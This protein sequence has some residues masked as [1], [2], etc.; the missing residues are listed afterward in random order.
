MEHSSEV[1]PQGR[2]GPERCVAWFAAGGASGDTWLMSTPEHSLSPDRPS[3]DPAH[4]LF[5]HA[6]FARTLAKAIAGYK[7]PDGIVLA[8]YGP[9]GSGKSTVLAFVEYELG[10]FDEQVR[11]VVVT[12]NP[13][14]FS[15]QEHLA[16]AFLGQL[17]AVLPAKHAGFKELGKRLAQFSGAIGGAVDVAGAYF[18]VPLGGKVVEAGAKLL[19]SKPKDVPA[20]KGAISELLN[21]EKKRVLV[22]VDDIDRLAP[23]EVRQ[24]FTVI[25]ALAD[26]PY[27]T[28]LLAFDR[29]VA[30]TAISQQT[31]LPGDRYLEKI[32]Q[33]PFEL[34]RADRVTLRQALFSK[35]DQVIAGTPEG[36]F[37]SGYWQNVFA[38]LDPLFT[39]PRDVVRLTNALSVTYPAVMGEV[40]PVD[41]IALECIRVF[42]PQ[43]Y[44]AIRTSP[45]KFAGYSAPEHHEKQAEQAFH[46][47]WLTKV[48]EALR[49]STKELLERLF[50]RLES[51]WSN[52]H[53]GGDSLLSW[54][55]DLRVCAGEDIF[56]AYFRL[57]L[58][59]G[60]VSRA[61]IDALLAA[62]P[63]PK[64]FADILRA[65]KDQ[66]VPNG[67]SKARALLERLMDFVPEEMQAEH[68]QPVINA[69]FQVGD[70]LLLASDEGGGF[71]GS[72]NEVRVARI[73]FHLLKK[74]EGPQRFSLLKS[75]F[76]DAAALRCSQR[77][78]RWLAEAAEKGE[79]DALLT[80]ESTDALMPVWVERVE[81][82][83]ASP[84]FINRP[85]LGSLLSG[86]RHWGDESKVKAW[87]QQAAATGDGLLKLIDA[88]SYEVRT[89][90]FGDHAVHTYRRVKPKTVE[91]YLAPEAAAERV[92][93]M[94]AA[95]AVPEKHLEVAKE[96]VRAW[97]AFKAGVVDED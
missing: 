54:R 23:E 10:R 91:S 1:R 58:P 13:W 77:L 5:G 94:L 74:V 69:L 22:I 3:T 59:P 45:E 89:Q 90:G 87:T 6:P 24:L 44:D 60:A 9:W 20:L 56:Q 16:R 57:S 4:D 81:L 46:Q 8:L 55:R 18:G 38:G 71:F 64:A 19:A 53:Y 33:V 39:V 41:F 76:A 61:D 86:W 27:V 49:P 47:Q 93:A 51:V 96:Y 21:K 43:V 32:I 70:E 67:L 26:F 66:K 36:L 72:G 88:L 35:L 80:K 73:A 42:L 25:K 29:E 37:N 31:G 68:A 48:P 63:E 84:E 12:F 28:Y 2:L 11:P 92:R 75:A 97:D 82:F 85:A 7:N 62:A 14:W 79:G 15:G 40:N 95:N 17:Q 30:S 83:A 34:P 65:A 78:L 50:P 52:V